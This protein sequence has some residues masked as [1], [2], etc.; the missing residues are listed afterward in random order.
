MERSQCSVRNVLTVR[1]REKKADVLVV[2]RSTRMF[3]PAAV[4]SSELL[5]APTTWAMFDMVS[6][7]TSE[8]V[9]LGV[10]DML[11]CGPGGE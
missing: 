7:S 4:S 3:I 11:D 10:N 1:S 6:R 8:F 9:S 5:E 2:Y